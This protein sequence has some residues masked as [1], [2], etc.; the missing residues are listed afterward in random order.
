MPRCE[1]GC[2][3]KIPVLRSPFLGGFL[4]WLLWTAAYCSGDASQLLVPIR[5]LHVM[6]ALDATERIE[7]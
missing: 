1:G 5:R 2:Q 4:V 7:Q 6:V 3:E